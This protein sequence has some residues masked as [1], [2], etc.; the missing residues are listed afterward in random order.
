MADRKFSSYAYEGLVIILSILIAFALD[1]GWADHQERRLERTVLR[2]LRDEFTSAEAR[3]VGS[4]AELEAVLTASR[5]LLSHLGPDA[6]ALAPATALDLADGILNLNTLEVPSS[7][8]DS[9]IA[10]G[11]LRLIS[12]PALRTGLAEW[13]ALVA[14][15]RE[16]HDWHR[17]ET[18]DFLVPYLARYLPLRNMNVA[19]GTD[20]VSPSGFD[21]DPAG[22]QHDPVFE[23]R[24]AN[25]MSRQIATYRESG[26]LLDATRGIVRSIDMQLA[27]R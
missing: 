23:G 9:V 20:W 14:D 18:D 2:E 7:V 1:A 15:V 13:P 10:T 26:I 27:G 11:Q 6:P 21:L 19:S 3:I 17:A 8:L 4:M 12:D 22:L 5:E 24:L 25:R 16:N